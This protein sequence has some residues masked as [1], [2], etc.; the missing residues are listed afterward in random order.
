[1]M[2]LYLFLAV[3]VTGTLSASECNNCEHPNIWV[4]LKFHI[5]SADNSDNSSLEADLLVYESTSMS[6]YHLSTCTKI[7]STFCILHFKIFTLL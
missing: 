5:T 2:A 1:M 4:Y 6:N 7:P 3:F